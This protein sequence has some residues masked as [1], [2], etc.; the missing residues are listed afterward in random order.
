MVD[1]TVRFANV[2]FENP[3]IVAS[4]EA[5]TNFE[6]MKKCVKA[7]AGGLVTKTVTTIREARR[8]LRPRW[9]IVDKKGFPEI[10]TFYSIGVLSQYE[11]ERFAE[12]VKR[13]KKELKVPIIVSIMGKEFDEWG[14]LAKLM[15]EAGADMIELNLS[16]PFMPETVKGT[17]RI[18][19]QDPKLSAE[20]VKVVREAASIPIIPKLSPEASDLVEIAKSVERAGASAIT[21]INRFM[22]IEIDIETGKPIIQ[23]AFAGYGGPYL[24]GIGL[25]WVAKI[26]PEVSIPVSGCAGI[27]NWSHAVEYFMVGATTVQLFTAIVAKGYGVIG[28]IVE[29]IKNF[30]E[31]HGYENI[32]AMRGIALKHIFPLSQLPV[33]SF[34]LKIDEDKCNGCGLCVRSCLAE[35][36]KIKTAGKKKVVIDDSKCEQCGLCITLC[37]SGALSIV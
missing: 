28:E 13:A 17:G 31:Q 30:M 4:G 33:S 23:S 32:E 36:I 10:F 25:R 11:P 18:I 35:A 14:Y 29:G 3:V 9:A 15:D 7:G 21:A 20:V 37:P 19:G 24:R 12:E 34:T 8:A 22:G 26:V 27:M 1:L 5:T 6:R 16:C 2:E